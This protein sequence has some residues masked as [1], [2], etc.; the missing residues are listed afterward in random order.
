MKNGIPYTLQIS[1]VNPSVD[2][3]FLDLGS[4]YGDEDMGSIIHATNLGPHP[5]DMAK[6]PKVADKYKILEEILRVVEGF[7]VFDVNALN[8][9]LVPDVVILP[10]F[11]VS[12][13]EKYKG[14][15]CLRNHLRMFW[16]KMDAYDYDKKLLIH[17]F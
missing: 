5:R 10:K 4:Q 7:N 13:F 6:E 17:R 3:N 2:D 1:I 16:R 11:K 12:D 9:C 8:M 14:L 15:G